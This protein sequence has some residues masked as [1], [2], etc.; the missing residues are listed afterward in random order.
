MLSLSSH[1]KL[2]SRTAMLSFQNLTDSSRDKLLDT[3]KHT[4]V[5]VPICNGSVKQTKINQQTFKTLT[6]GT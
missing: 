6:F 3:R 2:A 4:P 5:L 1:L